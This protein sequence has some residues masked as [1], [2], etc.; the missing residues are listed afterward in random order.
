[1]LW[2]C[3]GLDPDPDGV[4]QYPLDDVDKPTSSEINS[5]TNDRYSEGNSQ[6]IAT[7]EIVQCSTIVTRYF[8]K[9][10]VMY[11]MKLL[12]HQ[13]DGR[14]GYIPHSP[15]VPSFRLLRHMPPA[16]REDVSLKCRKLV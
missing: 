12:N 15:A 5:D 4:E 14:R 16:P 6:N 8:I 2:T 13:M 1:V 7:S 3:S 9:E 10:L 11:R